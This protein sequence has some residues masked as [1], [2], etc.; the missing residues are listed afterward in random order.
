METT[1][2]TLN[3]QLDEGSYSAPVRASVDVTYACDLRCIH[4]RTNTG[5]IP[6]EIRRRMLTIEQLADLM[7]QLDAMRVF[8]ITFTGGEPTVRAGFWDLLDTCTALRFSTVTLITNAAALTRRQMDR[9]LASGIRSVRVSIDGTR[10]VFH[11]VRK[12]DVFHRVIQNARYLNEHVPSFKL[13]TTV[14][15][16][17][18]DDIFNL[19][20]VL[21]SHGFRRQ[22][23]ILVRAHGRGGRNRLLLSEAQALDLYH[24]VRDFR[25]RVPHA[26]YDLNFNAPF[27]VSD[28][29][30]DPIQDVVLFPYLHK[31]SSVAISATGDVQMN[32]L[33]SPQPI[34]NVKTSPLREI[35]ARAQQQI[36]EEEQAF[37]DGRL[38]DLFWNFSALGENELIPLTSLL[39]RQIFEGARID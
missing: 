24:R 32:R 13:L 35:W 34:G 31:D 17:N 8:E 9:I 22:D 30:P 6:P 25:S 11:Q 15:S 18:F 23:L 12:K 27:L 33:Y 29:V 1:A 4:C 28:E 37:D 3:V 39:D 26:E 20:S 21:R 10:E 14:M 38:R 36:R 7:R 16:T 5:E 19:V 2:R